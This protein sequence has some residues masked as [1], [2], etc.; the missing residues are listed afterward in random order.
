MDAQLSL[1][2]NQVTHLIALTD[3][4]KENYPAGYRYIYSLIQD[5]DQ[6]DDGA[7]F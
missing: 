5:S 6:V 4:G 1:T 3:R 7:K 2:E